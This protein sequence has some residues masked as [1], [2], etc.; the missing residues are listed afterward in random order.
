[1]KSSGKSLMPEELYKDLSTA[2]MADLL[3]FI[4]AAN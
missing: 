4:E 3:A 1:M 2:Q